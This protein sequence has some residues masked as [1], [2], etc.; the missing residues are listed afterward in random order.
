[1]FQSLFLIFT[2]RSTSTRPVWIYAPVQICSSNDLNPS[3][4]GD[5]TRDLP[6]FFYLLYYRYSNGLLREEAD[7]LQGRIGKT[8]FMHHYF[9]P[10]IENLKT[11]TLR[12]IQKIIVINKNGLLGN[13]EIL[14]I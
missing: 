5:I 12:V 2:Y 14:L 3:H 13:K 1:L 10:N 6:I 11:K 9:N 4:S 7:L 8:V